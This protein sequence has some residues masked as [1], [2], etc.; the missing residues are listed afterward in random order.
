MADEPVC[1][2]AQA[3]DRQ[4]D[5]PMYTL[6]IKWWRAD[7]V[8]PAAD[9]TTLFIAAD[10]IQSHGEV[11]SDDQM[12]A[13]EPG[14]FQDY[15]VAAEG[16]KVKGRLICAIRNGKSM[17]YLASCAWVLG[18]DGRTIERLA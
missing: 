9:E 13:W 2:S 3:I 6:K 5:R 17:W 15:R 10:E 8:S 18:P 16:A 11:T 12:A 14:D 1:A 4:K 7:E